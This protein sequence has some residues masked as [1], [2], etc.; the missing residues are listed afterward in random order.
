MNCKDCGQH[1]WP[2]EARRSSGAPSDYRC[3]KC[4]AAAKAREQRAPWHR[5]DCE[6]CNASFQTPKEIPEGR[7]LCRDCREQDVRE[8][9]DKLVPYLAARLS[10][11]EGGWER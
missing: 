5:Y 2:N 10:E 6:R 8:R 7:R 11:M 4:D 1:I 3:P 9:K